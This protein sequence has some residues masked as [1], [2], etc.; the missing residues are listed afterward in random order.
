MSEERIELDREA[1]RAEIG[2]RWSR[3]E[4]DAALDLLDNSEGRFP[5]GTRRLPPDLVAAVQRQRLIAGA[6]KASSELGYRLTNVQDIIDRAGVSRPTFYEH[7]SNKEDCF[8]CAFDLT[9][10]R[11]RQ[12]MSAAADS[13]ESCRE[14]LRL[15]LE[16]LLRFA[17]TEPDAARTVIVEARAACAEAVLRRDAEMK[18]FAECIEKNVR[19]LLPDSTSH[20]PIAAAGIV[21]GVEAVLYSRLYKGEVE[22]LEA[23][24]PSL[25][26]FVILP[27]EGHEAASEEL[28]LAIS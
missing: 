20:S 21:G 2:G 13:G 15:G 25:M 1:L 28:A 16:E 10:T 6:L 17:A 3:V 22:S 19:E 5:G 9:A 11:L 18:R 12:R 4:V 8:L 23:L 27:F 7:F 26:Y 24:L 14:R